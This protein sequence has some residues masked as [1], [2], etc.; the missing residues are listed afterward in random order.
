MSTHPM[1]ARRR[2]AVITG[3]ASGIGPAAAR[4]FAAM[5]MRGHGACSARGCEPAYAGSGAVWVAGEVGLPMNDAGTAPD[6]DRFL[7]EA[8]K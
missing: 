7:G 6:G 4:R 1:L 5:G 8:H 2:A 3:A